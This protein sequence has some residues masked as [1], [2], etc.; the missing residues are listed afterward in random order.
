MWTGTNLYDLAD[1]AAWLSNSTLVS[2]TP[3]VTMLGPYP[4]LATLFDNFDFNV[5]NPL[6]GSYYSFQPFADLRFRQAFADS[7]NMSEIN[8]DY[9]NNLGI[10]AN[11]LIA[12][13]LAPSAAYNTSITPTYS[14]NPD[15]V[16]A[17]LLSAMM[18]PITH[19]TLPNG[20]VAPPGIFNNSFGCS[21]LN[22]NNQCSNPVAQTLNLVFATGDVVDQAIFTQMAEVLNNVSQTYN[23]GLTISVTPLPSGPFYSE[24]GAGEVYINTGGWGA[25][26]PWI[27]DFITG[28]FPPGG[29]YPLEDRWNSSQMAQLYH[30]SVVANE[31]GNITE[32]VAFSNQMNE[33]A[34]QNVIYLWTIF[35]ETV[36]AITSNVQGV[37]FNASLYGHTWL[38]YFALLY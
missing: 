9:N 37:Y 12:P 6:T 33:F 22:S 24:S 14:Y 28:A 2:V 25:D 3:G 23:M 17:L 13:G 21:T 35:P 19:F 29:A 34:N 7:V 4:I 38:L 36:A 11:D 30:Q 8:S 10:V 27:M 16:Q 20:T 31:E 26:Y 18:N 1:R 15:K 5:T 32:L